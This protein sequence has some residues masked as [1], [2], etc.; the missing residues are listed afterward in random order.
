M[1]SLFIA[2]IARLRFCIR[3]LASALRRCYS[4]ADRRTGNP[5]SPVLFGPILE[6]RETNKG[7][8]FLRLVVLFTTFFILSSQAFSAVVN[9]DFGYFGTI[10][11]G[12]AL[13]NLQINNPGEF[14]EISIG[15]AG[16]PELDFSDGGVLQWFGQNGMSIHDPILFPRITGGKLAVMQWTEYSPDGPIQNPVSELRGQVQFSTVSSELVAGDVIAPDLPLVIAVLI[17]G[18]DD[19]FHVCRE[20]AATALGKYGASASN[21]VP[22]LMR[23]IP[24]N[25][26]AYAALRQIDPKTSTTLEAAR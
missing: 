4:R 9:V 21:A 23:I 16:Y 1:S 26:A 13:I 18:L 22:V 17:K 5:R 10:E 8:R 25:S 20:N 15:S 6:S 3:S 12:D 11:N 7:A 24:L 14:P 2:L 19:S